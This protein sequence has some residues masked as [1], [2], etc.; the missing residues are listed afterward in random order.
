MRVANTIEVRLNNA[1]NILYEIECHSGITNAEIAQKRG[2]SSPTI[3][4]I[5]NILKGSDI[6]MAAGTGE[7]S[8]GR[9]PLQLSLNSDFQNYIGVSIAKHTL[10]ITRIDFAGVIHEKEL[11][12]KDF[13][14]SKTYWE[15]IRQIVKD[16]EA[17]AGVSCKCGLALPGFVDIAANVVED[18]QTLGVPKLSL[19]D[20]YD[21]FGPEVTVGDSCYLAGTAQVFGKDD[22][23]D[24]CFVLLSRRISGT[25]FRGNEIIKMKKSSMDIGMMILNPYAQTSKYG[26]PGSFLELCSAS[27]IIDI[28]KESS[29]DI[30][31]DNF[32]K[33]IENGNKKYSAMW[34]EYLKHLTFALHNIFAFFGIDIVIGGEMAKYIKAYE[35]KLKAYHEKMILGGGGNARLRFS[36]YG[37]YDEAYGAALEARR[38]HI[39]EVLPDILKNAAASALEQSKQKTKSNKTKQKQ[40]G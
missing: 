23:Q 20:I 40:T 36:T 17:K 3:S 37:E 28:L 16:F 34:D 18:T 30:I 35:Y 14:A 38:R 19:N 26:L 15:E 2:L 6:L 22:Y 11:I 10:Y 4:N 39:Q 29:K 32:F 5:V 8:G 24:S 12:Y 9:R 7:S 1:I 13:E 31:Y 33:E 25:V 27:K 21:V